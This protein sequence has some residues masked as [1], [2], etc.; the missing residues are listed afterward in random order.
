MNIIITIVA[1]IFL[2]AILTYLGML[3]DRYLL[4]STSG[5]LN[6]FDDYN[7]KKK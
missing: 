4:S 1:W 2:I 6:T 7:H 3:F 5:Y